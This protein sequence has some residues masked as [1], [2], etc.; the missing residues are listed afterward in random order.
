MFSKLLRMQRR[1]RIFC[2]GF[3]LSL[4]S[5]PAF[6]VDL[7]LEDCLAVAL[8]DNPTIK[9]ADMEITKADYSKKETLGALLPSI[10]FDGSYNRTVKKQV[11]YMGLGSFGDMGDFGD[12]GGEGSDSE[13]SPAISSGVDEGFKVGLDNMYSLGFQFSMPLIAPQLWTSLK[14]SDVQI[15][16]AAEQA[17]ASRIDMVNQVKNAFYALLLAYDS[18]KVVEESYAMAELTHS[19]YKKRLA[20]GDASEYDVLRT[21]VAMKNIEPELIQCDIAVSRA[22]LQ[23]A[24][25]MG[26]DVDTPFTIVGS[27]ADYE[28]NMYGDVL[29]IQPDL[30]QNTSL[31]MNDIE[32]LALERTLKLQK[33]AWWP[34]LALGAN[35]TWNSS[36]N[37]SPFKNFRW[38]PYSVVG[39][40][41][42]VPIF[43]GGQRYARIKQARIQL[44][45]ME[46]TREN[47]VRTINSQ[48]TLAI[49]NIQLNV[50]QIASSKESVA[51]ADRAHSIQQKSFEIGAASYL[52]LRDSELS[53]TRAKLAYYQSLYNF[54]VANSDLELLLGNAPV[55][56]YVNK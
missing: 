54:M 34:T 4:L 50:K 13:D 17:R 53:L 56:S 11:M 9:V 29:S 46:W 1:L 23:L 2:V 7:T 15:A 14:L 18:K 55:E 26:V 32:T 36:S 22:H 33:S 43:Q 39:L 6:S 10:S 38:T 40:S 41:L 44:D 45:Q 48:V 27:L 47:L 5:F 20:V 28:S 42:S 8:T 21:S 3:A 16:R 49:D 51:E 19:V 52:E 12:M 37:G 25:L 24:I 35:Y 30:S 31:L